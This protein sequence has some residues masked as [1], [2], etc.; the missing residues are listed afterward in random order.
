MHIIVSGLDITWKIMVFW[1]V[2]L[3]RMHSSFPVGKVTNATI[4]AILTERM[5]WQVAQDF[6]NKF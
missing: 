6:H 3:K 4:D 2:K 1:L 5:G